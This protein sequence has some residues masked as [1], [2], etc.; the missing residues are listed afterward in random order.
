MP[1][2]MRCLQDTVES[3][4]T[5]HLNHGEIDGYIYLTV[6]DNFTQ[7][8]ME[9]VVLDDKLK[10][11]LRSIS[12]HW[13][14]YKERIIEKIREKYSYDDEYDILHTKSLGTKTTKDKNKIAKYDDFVK[15]IKDY[16]KTYK[17]SL[18]LGG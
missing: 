10:E 2:I 13:Q 7:D 12:P 18:G 14:R 8:K 3:I 4:Q 6:P 15:S 9:D 5:E 11:Q 16:Y 1:K 17:E